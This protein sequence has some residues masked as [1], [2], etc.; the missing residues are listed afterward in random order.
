MRSGTILAAFALALAFQLPAGAQTTASKVEVAGAYSYIRLNLNGPGFTEGAQTN[1][2]TGSLAIN[3]THSLGIVGEIG[4]YKTSTMYKAGGQN[5]SFTS[6]LF[7][8]RYNIRK[9]D[10]LTPYFQTLVGGVKGNHELFL[11]GN[12]AAPI[13]RTDQSA[14]AWTLGGGLDAKVTRCLAVRVFQ[15]E[16]MLTKWNNFGVGHQNSFRVETGLVFRFGKR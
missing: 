12:P 9:W 16:Y 14:L 13:I 7:G 11:G 2:G 1:G 5:V 4:G 15:A 8:P 10:T 3:V 6:F